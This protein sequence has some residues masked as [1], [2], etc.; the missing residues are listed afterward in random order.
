M[1]DFIRE[2]F[3]ANRV[4][5]LFVYGQVFFVLGLVIALQSWQH[6]RLALA[7]HLKWLALF[8]FTHGLHEW[9]DVFIP[10]QAQYLGESLIELLLV[11]QAMLLAISFACLFQ[12][13]VENLRPL[14]D[15][16]AWLRYL[17]GA[18]LVLWIFVAFGPTL[19]TTGDAISW[20]RLNSIWARYTM[21]FPGAVLAAISLRRQARNLTAPVEMPRIWRTLQIA[22]LALAGYA[23]VGGLAVPPANFI[24]VKWFNADLLEQWTLIPVQVYRSGLG[25]ILTL[26]IFR[27]LGVFQVELDRRLSHMEEAQV[28]IAERE[29]IGRELHDGTLQTIYAAGLLLQTSGKE[30]AQT[31]CPPKSLSQ[32]RQSVALLNDAVADIRGYIGT[33]RAQPNT[34]SLVAGL[35]ELVTVGHLRSLVEID[36]D[37]SLPQN[38]PITP[39]Q[40]GHLLAITNEA[41]SNVAR[42]ARATKIRL[43]AKI[44][45]NRLCLEIQDDGRGLP[46]DY[47]IGYGL[48]NMRDRAR[49]LG[50]DMV[51]D[52]K[53]GHGTTVTVEVPWDEKQ[54]KRVEA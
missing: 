3:A 42:H 43:T 45:D 25:L 50:G 53:P 8:G 33:L 31:K 4:I 34:R 6:S 23:L 11:L 46:N 32:L 22:G 24:P 40:V 20:A 13:G 37:V 54:G 36:L 28:L 39:A 18:A 52:T 9:G 7:R 51:L 17:P 1:A 26:A 19:S 35:H 29:R 21:G 38:Q 41:L 14:P 49:M 12:F 5:I 44:V 16:Q 15:K 30:L 27:A 48:R 47:V 10:L 2:I